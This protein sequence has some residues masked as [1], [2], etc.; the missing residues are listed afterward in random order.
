MGRGKAKRSQDATYIRDWRTVTLR[1]NNVSFKHMPGV[2]RP[3]QPHCMST[4]E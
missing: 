3:A 2:L 1:S 4:L